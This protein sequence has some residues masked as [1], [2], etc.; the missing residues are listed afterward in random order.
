MKSHQRIFLIVLVVLLVIACAGLI[1]TSGWSTRTVSLAKRPPSR[2]QSPVDL[3]QFQMAQ[4]LVAVAATPEEQDLARDALRMAD[5]EVDFAFASAIYQAAFQPVPSTP[6]I[7]AILG[8]ISKAEQSVA[9][10]DADIARLTKLLAGPKENQ[11]EAL[12]QQLELAKAR[13]ELNEDELADADQDLERAGGDPRSRIQRMVDEHTASEQ[14]SGGQLDLSIV[15]KQAGATLP[16]SNSF[17]SVAGAW[18]ALRSI[19]G[20]L[21]RAEQEANTA[22][23]AFSSRHDELER[24]LEQAESQQSKKLAGASSGAASGESTA[25]A[26][27]SAS[28][29]ASAAIFSYRSLTTMQRRMS[30]LDSRIRNQQDLAGTYGQWSA[31]TALR[32]RSMLHTLFAAFA[33]MLLIALAVLIANRFVERIFNRLEPDQKR[34]LTLRAVLHITMRAIGAILILLVIFGPPSQMATVLALAGAGLTVALKDFIVGFFGWFVL[35][36]K[37]GIRHGDWVEIN[38]VSGE[39]IEIGLFHT[40][41]L[42]TGNWNDAGHPTGRRVTFVN[43][44][45]IEGH[46]FNFSTSGQWLWDELEVALPADQDPYPIVEEIQKIVTK[47]TAA[48]ARLAEQEWERVENTRGTQAVSA[49]PAISVRPANLGFAIMVRYVTRANQRHQQRLKLYHDIVDLLRRKNISEPA[50]PP[51]AAAS[52]PATA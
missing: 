29:Q 7:K 19:V 24:Q 9:E 13:Q 33:W 45:A 48:N 20:R 35:M 22:A 14:N 23:A 36:G 51:P 27:S 11:K 1:L 30:S 2:S 8:R 17:L 49:G 21:D 28:D 37:N 31:L 18:Y 44:Y 47:E 12:T 6:E 46:Y 16:V 34:L 38:G 3:R 40:V 43:S 4:A 5:H 41:L 42:E 32:G 39:V 26:P 52:K 50:T 25:G 15:G 10:N